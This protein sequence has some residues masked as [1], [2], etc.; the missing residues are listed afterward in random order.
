MSDRYTLFKINNLQER[1]HLESTIESVKRSYNISPTQAASV[2]VEKDGHPV[3]EKMKWGFVPSGAKDMNS[4]FRYKTF[5]ARSE[6]IFSKSQWN[7]AIRNRRCLVPA[8][9]F[10]VWHA[11][12]E[13]KK[14]YYV[15]PK[16]QEL[17]AFAG[18]YN[19][20]KDPEG[21]EWGV[22]SLVTVE[23]NDDLH[24]L[25]DRMPVILTSEGESQWLDSSVDSAS[26]L[27]NIMRPYPDGELQIS[28]VGSDIN[29]VKIDNPRLITPLS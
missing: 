5:N 17:F 27:Y 25:T 21:K 28:A 4:V 14:P 20:W 26:I 19:S 3:L 13:G 11:S 1:F 7:E 24:S 16:N 22:Y 9:G 2:I 29:S 18:I 23:S 6:G 10:Y 15:R 8:N 12:D